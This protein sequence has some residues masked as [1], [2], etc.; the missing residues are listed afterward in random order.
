M[1]DRDDRNAPESVEIA[2]R[3]LVCQVCGA[4]GFLQ[5]NAQLHGPTAT[6]FGVEWTSP[7]AICYVCAQCGYIH[8][9]LPPAE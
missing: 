7:T 3:P 4:D 1:R 9:F 6:F 8:W 5:R 2:G